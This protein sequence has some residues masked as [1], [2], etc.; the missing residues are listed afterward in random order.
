[1]FNKLAAD[2]EMTA[3]EELVRSN[4][5]LF[6]S[7]SKHRNVGCFEDHADTPLYMK[8]GEF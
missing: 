6:L 7:S 4:A 2:S 3:T 8:T 1:M 5:I